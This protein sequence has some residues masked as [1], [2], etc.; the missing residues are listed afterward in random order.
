MNL[1]RAKLVAVTG[2]PKKETAQAPLE[3]RCA[4]F[5]LVFGH[6]A[7]YATACKSATQKTG[8]LAKPV[9]AGWRL[10]A[11]GPSRPRLLRKP[12]R[13]STPFGVPAK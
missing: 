3:A 9:T 4:A 5:G 10:S 1:V 13:F 11:Q 7:R 12:Q 2:K 8:K 6:R